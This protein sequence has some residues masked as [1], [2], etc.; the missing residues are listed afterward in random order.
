MFI[1]CVGAFCVWWVG[2]SELWC[3]GFWCSVSCGVEARVY[4]VNCCLVGAHMCDDDHTC[5]PWLL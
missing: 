1:Y 3:W 2:V 4:V 5:E